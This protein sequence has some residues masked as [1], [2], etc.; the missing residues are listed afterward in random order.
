MIVLTKP[1]LKVLK[2]MESK[3]LPES[4][5]PNFR[6][7]YENDIV[8]PVLTDKVDAFGARIPSGYYAVTNNYWRYKEAHRWF[9]GEFI[10]RNIIVPIVVGVLSVVITRYLVGP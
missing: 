1:E 4:E 3:A 6:E 7:L 8:K 2:K 5:I 9:N 10:V